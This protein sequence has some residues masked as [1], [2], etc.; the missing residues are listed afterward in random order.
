MAAPWT[1]VNRTDPADWQADAPVITSL[2][3][4]L[5]APTNGTV[6]PLDLVAQLETIHVC[7][8]LP[9]APPWAPL[10]TKFS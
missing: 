2:S 4:E 8:H 1:H 9:G 3:T 5:L 10:R 6:S 7:T